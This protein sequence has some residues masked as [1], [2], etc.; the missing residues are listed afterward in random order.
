MEYI[1]HTKKDIAA[2]KCALGLDPTQ[3][4]PV[5]APREVLY[6]KPLRVPGPFSEV[7]LARHIEQHAQKNT[8]GNYRHF[9]G[10]GIYDHY[11]PAAVTQLANR[12][13]FVTAYTPYQAEMSQGILQ[14]M[15]EY[16]TCVANLTGMEISNASLYDGATALFEAIKMAIVIKKRTKVV[17]PSL[18]NPQYRD[19]VATSFRSSAITCVTAQEKNGVMD[20]ASCAALCDEHTAAVVVQQPNFFGNVEDIA[21]IADAAHRVGALCIVVVYPIALGILKTPGSCGADIVVGE[22]QSLGLPQAFGGLTLGF[23]ATKKAYIRAIPGRIVGMTTN[24]KREQGFVLTMQAREQHIRRE[25]ATSNI[26][27]NQAWC[28][29]NATIYLSLMGARGLCAVALTCL[30]N[31]HYFAQQL[32]A[33]NGLSL[34]YEK[35]FFNEFVLKLDEKKDFDMMHEALKQRGVMLGVSLKKLNIEKYTHHWLVCVTEKKTKQKLDEV[36]RIVE[37]TI[38]I[39]ETV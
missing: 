33:I 13:E 17:M 20:G 16:Q 15:F 35:G 38:K 31:A 21:A 32:A 5:D 36:V 25:K 19:V 27:S 11:I 37:K 23:F 28:A 10:A 26:C 8:Y 34:V 14:A 3:P 22:G 4:F 1:P 18:L 24:A 12:S 29:L 9:L 6:T 39:E 30:E 7:E 2:M